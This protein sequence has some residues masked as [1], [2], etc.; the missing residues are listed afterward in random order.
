MQTVVQTLLQTLLHCVVNVPSPLGNRKD[1]N[2]ISEQTMRA[3]RL[4]EHT[5]R[6]GADTL[7]CPCPRRMSYLQCRP[8]RKHRCTSAFQSGLGHCR[9]CS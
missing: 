8:L 9:Q 7:T 1:K 4:A 2:S 6:A 3:L 5:E